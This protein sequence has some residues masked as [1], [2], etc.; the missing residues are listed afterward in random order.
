MST[1]L[2][3]Y[4]KSLSQS[5]R[6][7]IAL[8][9]SHAPHMDRPYP[10]VLSALRKSADCCKITVLRNVAK[11]E[12]AGLLERETG[13]TGSRYG[14]LITLDSTTCAVFMELYENEYG[15][16]TV[17]DRYQGNVTAADRYQART[18]EK[19]TGTGFNALSGLDLSNPVDELFMRLSDQGKRVLAHI[20]SIF[21]DSEESPIPLFIQQCA[22]RAGCSEVT[23]RR[24]IRNSHHAG[25]FDKS[26]HERGPRYGLM[27]TPDPEAVKRVQRLL[28]ALPPA[29]ATEAVTKADRY[30]QPVTGP[31]R[32]HDRID[33][34]QH[35]Y[36]DRYAVTN[37]DRMEAQPASTCS[38]GNYPAQSAPGVTGPDRYQQ[39]PILDREI[40]YLS[41]AR[42]DPEEEQRARR[43]LSFST[44]DFHILWPG[45]HREG[46]GPDQISQIVKHRLSFDETILDI[47]NSL[48]AAEYELERESF[49]KARKGVCNYLFATLK[50]KG[51]WRRPQGFLTPNEQAL[52]NAE[53]ERETLRKL[54]DLEHKKEK[55]AEQDKQDEKFEAWLAGLSDEE[56][57]RIDE[58]CALPMSTDVAKRS[59]RKR[60]WMRNAG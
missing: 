23:A 55:R 53:K 52:A 59:W 46:F 41:N 51:C 21:N 9:I 1:D 27:L 43:L 17:P 4:Y 49:P 5:G 48:Y 35:T 24:T 58:S 18:P 30:H 50:N 56:I 11:A 25:I 22:D 16:V 54:K 3:N 38:P 12:S 8:L 14:S 45:L 15:P 20:C 42:E 13:G 10:C 40:K 44:D 32:N 33:T 28:S 60:W 31:D 34:D 36:P 47:E 37:A 2:N 6:R 19:S 29:A 39:P 7:V 57:T 26:T